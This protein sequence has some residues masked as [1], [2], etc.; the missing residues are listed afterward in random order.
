MSVLFLNAAM[1]STAAS[2][3]L[4]AATRMECSMPSESVKETRQ[5]RTGTVIVWRNKGEG[6]P[7][8]SACL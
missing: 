4:S 1:A 8:V 7:G 2:N 5:E 3:R 6:M